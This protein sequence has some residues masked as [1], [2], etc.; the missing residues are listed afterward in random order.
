MIQSPQFCPTANASRGDEA[1]S[2]NSTSVETTHTIMFRQ[3]CPLGSI[4]ASILPAQGDVV[5]PQPEPGNQWQS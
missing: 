2:S 5:Q 1:G 4:G 3:R